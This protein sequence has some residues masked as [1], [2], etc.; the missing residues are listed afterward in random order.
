M[1]LALIATAL[2]VGFSGP[3]GRAWFARR[4]RKREQELARVVYLPSAACRPRSRD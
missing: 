1:I 3:D 4:R 2:A